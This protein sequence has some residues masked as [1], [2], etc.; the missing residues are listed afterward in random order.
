MTQTA[1]IRLNTL[2]ARATQSGPQQPAISLTLCSAAQIDFAFINESD[3]IAPLG[4]TSVTVQCCVKAR[5]DDAASLLLDASCAYNE[6]EGAAARYSAAWTAETLDGDPLRAFLGSYFSRVGTD[7][8]G[9]WM[10]VSWTIDGETLRVAFPITI[11]NAWLRPEDTAPDPRV[12]AAVV[13][14]AARALLFGQ[15]QVLS[16]EQRT[17]ALSNLGLMPDADGIVTWPTGHSLV[18]NAP[19]P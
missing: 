19:P 10:E 6:G 8:R 16:P 12:D 2:A 13:W 14:L 5:P 15:P 18:L 9:P 1:L 17:Q 11:L 4:G 7:Q 3:E